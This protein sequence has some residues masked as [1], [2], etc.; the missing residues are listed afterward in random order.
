M[1]FTGDG[2]VGGRSRSPRNT[3]SPFS[4][5]FF[6][7]GG[8]GMVS[9][10]ASLSPTRSMEI[11]KLQ[12][13]EST[14]WAG[15][16]KCCIYGRDYLF[17][18]ISQHL[19]KASVY[20]HLMFSCIFLIFSQ[21]IMRN[22]LPGKAKQC[23]GERGWLSENWGAEVSE[24]TFAQL[25]LAKPLPHQEQVD[26]HSLSW[27]TMRQPALLVRDLSGHTTAA[28]VHL[29]LVFSSC[30]FRLWLRIIAISVDD[31]WQLSQPLVP[32]RGT[33]A[34]HRFLH[35]GWFLMEIWREKS[36]T[37]PIL[38]RETFNFRG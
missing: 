15:V 5:S 29:V 37:F 22:S 31:W 18:I 16:L 19:L 9:L 34:F 4:G 1:M 28:L 13:T 21:I 35:L 23:N 17:L 36:D 6:C 12:D 11:R 27:C 38:W 7:D 3:G 20:F 14:W 25:P 24:E 10:P 2:P 8:Q 26:H 33:S 32:K 30:N